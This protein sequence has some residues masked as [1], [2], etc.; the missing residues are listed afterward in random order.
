MSARPRASARRCFIDV[1]MVWVLS[2]DL[3]LFPGELRG[4]FGG[5]EFPLL[6][7][8]KLGRGGVDHHFLERAGEAVAGKTSCADA[9]ALMTIAAASTGPTAVHVPATQDLF[10]FVA[11]V[12]LPFVA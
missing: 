9:L 10:C 11:M 2:V 6:G 3:R 8:G 7:G 5:L 1:F 4:A 12:W